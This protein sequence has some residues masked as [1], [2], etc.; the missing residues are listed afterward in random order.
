MVKGSKSVLVVSVINLITT[1]VLGAAILCS[2][3]FYNESRKADEAK[4]ERHKNTSP[5][6]LETRDIELRK[7]YQNLYAAYLVHNAAH[8]LLV[9]NLNKDAPTVLAFGAEQDIRGLVDM[10]YEYTFHTENY[11]PDAIA[12]AA[13]LFIR[14]DTRLGRVTYADFTDDKDIAESCN[15]ARLDFV[16]LAKPFGEALQQYNRYRPKD[17]WGNPTDG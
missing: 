8:G 12:K 5:P 4:D 14:M 1:V 6:P 15:N 13:E 10:A 16:R 2:V 17:S 11:S 7:A 9:D 3:I